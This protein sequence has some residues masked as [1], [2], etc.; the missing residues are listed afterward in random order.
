MPKH[1]GMGE[2]NALQARH[3]R[4]PSRT[5][6]PA[7]LRLPAAEE[8]PSAPQS[9][10]T[11]PLAHHSILQGWLG[12]PG[13]E[14]ASVGVGAKLSH[15][16]AL[17]AGATQP[18]LVD[19]LVRQA[20]DGEALAGTRRLLSGGQRGWPRARRRGGRT[21][22]ARS[23]LSTPRPSTAASSRSSTRVK[24]AGS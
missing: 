5:P 13:L 10:V 21:I 19:G 1:N 15:G 18:A 4:P 7:P 3:V 23:S 20:A 8:P 17:E 12:A 11:G 16:L 9:L 22:R 14:S 2:L 6:P 24:R